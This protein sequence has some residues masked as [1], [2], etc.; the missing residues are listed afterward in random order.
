MTIT[1]KIRMFQWAAAVSLLLL[2]LVSS[3]AMLRSAEDQ[4]KIQAAYEHYIDILTLSKRANRFSEQIA[5]LILLGEETWP[6]Y[7]LARNEL[8]DVFTTL[9]NQMAVSGTDNEDE[10]KGACVF[11]DP[12]RM[13]DLRALFNDIEVTVDEILALMRQGRIPEATELFSRT[14]ETDFDSEVEQL[15]ADARREE[16]QSLR[17]T[18]A[19][20]AL[21]RQRVTV[22]FGAVVLFIVL[23][24]LITSVYIKRALVYP[25]DRLIQGVQKIG[26]GDLDHRITDTGTGE[27]SGVAER[28]N[29]MAQQLNDQRDRLLRAHA[30]LEAEV[31]QRT[32]ELTEANQRLTDLDRLRVRFLADISHE[33]RTPLT[34]LRGEAEIALRGQ[35]N[36]PQNYREALERIFRKGKE[37]SGMV[38]DLLFLARAEADAIRFDKQRSCLQEI[39]KTTLHDAHIIA[40][41]HEIVISES[42]PGDEILIEADPQRLKQA[43][44]VL[45]IN[46][47]QHSDNGS[48]ITVDASVSQNS[49]TVRIKDTGHGIP[50]EDLPYVFERFYRSRNDGKARKHSGNGIGLHIA[51]W[52]VEK[53]LGSLTL[54]SDTNGTLVTLSLP[55]LLE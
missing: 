44:M 19:E 43:L 16:Q 6:D 13:A 10:L 54:A 36:Q 12:R 1:A 4:T 28:I 14:I 39:L 53:H 52:I 33:L 48:R 27:L 8:K 32:A 5:E 42:L 26:K 2:I 22:F 17:E 29:E 11:C 47:I 45:I 21:M 9:E 24:T 50:G 40:W 51:K 41:K 46:A 7:Q 15:L 37:M 55:R 34:V 35:L 3:L 49:A 38:D 30:S 25:I 18:E 23:T 20:A 31:R